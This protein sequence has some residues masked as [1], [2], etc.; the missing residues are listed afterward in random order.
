MPKHQGKRGAVPL[1]G[2]VGLDVEHV[3]TQDAGH[4][5]G[6]VGEASSLRDCAAGSV[7][8]LRG[9]R[10]D[11]VVMMCLLRRTATDGTE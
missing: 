2:C 9:G 10:D 8:W 5:D 7:T 1:L 6:H 4:A 3:P 11:E